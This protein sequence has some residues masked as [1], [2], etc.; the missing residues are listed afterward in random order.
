MEEYQKRVMVEYTELNMK[1][2]SL[3]NFIRGSKFRDV[4]ETDRHLLTEQQYSMTLYSNVLAKRIANFELQ[5]K[6]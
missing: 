4:S 2:D 6:E 3:T 5:T 1:L